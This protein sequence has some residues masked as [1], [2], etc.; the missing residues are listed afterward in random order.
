MKRIMITAL[1][2][3]AMGS[4][5][6]AEEPAG[7][8]GKA[9]SHFATVDKFRVHYK[10]FGEGK[11]AVVFIHGSACDMTMWRFQA[12]AFADK[13]RVILI[14]LP[15]HGQ[16]DKPQID[17]TMDLFARAI[18]A[19]LKDAGV[20]QVVLVGASMGTPV[21]RQFWRLYPAK[22]V[23]LVAVDGMIAPLPFPGG[24]A[25]VKAHQKAMESPE[26]K[27][28]MLKFAD[29]TFGNLSAKL[30]Q[31][32]KAVIASTP[33]HVALGLAKAMEAPAVWEDDPIKV[34]VQMILCSA[35]IWPADYEKQVEKIAANLEFHRLSDVGHCMMLEKPDEFNALLRKFLE[36]HGG[37]KGDERGNLLEKAP[38]RFAQFEKIRVHYK[39]LGEGTIPVVFVHGAFSDMTTWRFQ[40]PAL[41][42]KARVI[43]I[44]LPGHGQSDKP[45]IDYSM[46]VFARAIDAVL[47]DVGVEKAVLVGHSM[48][49]PVARQFWRLYPEKIAALVAVEGM[50]VPLPFVAPA[51][52]KP[53]G[54]TKEMLLRSVDMAFGKDAPVE[55]RQ[56]LKAVIAKM[57]D[58]VVE[59]TMKALADP[60]MWKD[61]PIKVPVQMILC[62]N[63]FS[64]WPADYEQQVRKIA[65]QL[66][67]QRIKEA[68]HCLMLEKPE[69]F[70]ALLNGFLKQ[71]GVVSP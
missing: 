56:S 36:R 43:L 13:S 18:D 39:S 15:G 59:S 29:M 61:D 31:S 45:Q 47:K 48:G 42:D 21:A 46:D 66:E 54:Q 58:H 70:N 4:L 9:P 25:Q 63:R 19:V 26:Y 27:E 57:P 6:R 49:T 5:A 23:A 17:Y 51:A 33:Q 50:I 65:P 68:G 67:F 16:S 30:R 71:H 60:S 69:E 38:S 24:A 22:T 20:E 55:V 28:V 62:V 64:I 1:F 32:M 52:V 12:P 41:A 7:A 53:S 34:P 10:S 11:T 35:P 14:D 3:T 37:A 8:L 40:V 2:A 44:D